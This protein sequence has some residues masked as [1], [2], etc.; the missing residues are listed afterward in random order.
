[1]PTPL[2][3]VGT[4]FDC[5]VLISRKGNGLPRPLEGIIVLKSGPSSEMVDYIEYPKRG[6]L[7]RAFRTFRH[8]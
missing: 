4:S 2:H 6:V 7:R 1:M 3:K 5:F 8:F